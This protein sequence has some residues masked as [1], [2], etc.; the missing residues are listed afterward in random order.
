MTLILVLVHYLLDCGPGPA[1]NPIDCGIIEFI[2]RKMGGR[3]KK[4]LGVALR[5]GVLM[6][7]DQQVVTGIAILSAGY[8]QLHCGLS[9]YHWQIIVYLAWFSS[10][11][12]LT[13][14]TVLR[15]YFRNNPLIRNWRAA[16]M[17]ATVVLLGVALLPT[18]NPVWG[19]TPGVPAQCFFN[20]LDPGWNYDHRTADSLHYSSAPSV[21]ISLVVLSVSFV[22]RIITLFEKSSV[23]TTRWMRSKPGGLLKRWLCE[24]NNQARASGACFLWKL[25][26]EILLAVYVM[27][28]AIFD[29]HGSILWEVRFPN[30]TTRDVG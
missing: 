12:H 5:R 27:L 15:Q 24:L 3:P 22:T 23:F 19:R 11:T 17:L 29:L 28:K 16:F 9:S 14:L 7:S 8:S 2:W 25:V 10:V 6:F 1:V 26:H 30:S 18:A 4:E 13:T 21:Y 20:A